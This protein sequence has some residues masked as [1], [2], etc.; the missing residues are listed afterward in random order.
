MPENV[1]SLRE[2]LDVVNQRIDRA[3]RAALRNR[4]GMELIA[5]T[6]RQPLAVLKRAYALGLRH[7]GENQIQEGVPKV[8]ASPD[9]IIWHF[10]GHLQKN[11]VR[12]AVKYFHYIH[13]VDSLSLL[14]RIDAISA[15]ERLH[16]K[17]FLQVNYALD[18][19]KHG[20]HPEA[21]APVLG[22]AI[23]LRNV[24]CIGLM[25]VPPLASSEAETESYFQGLL[26]IRNTLKENTPDWPGLLS[27]GMSS[28]F[29]IA[30]QNGSH[31][32]RIGSSLF[33]ERH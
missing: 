24:T 3:L 19:D 11:K 18:P 31:Y 1:S 33:G 5:V 4:S 10:I 12:K 2:N 20:L 6:K 7:F 30:L 15:E 14:Q 27:L 13:S 21:V 8:K 22:A 25:G 32:I 28:D 16:P 26:S 9:D 17:L 29:E 23:S